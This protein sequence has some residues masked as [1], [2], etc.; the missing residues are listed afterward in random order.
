MELLISF[1]ASGELC[2]DLS[3]AHDLDSKARMSSNII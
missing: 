2:Q 3:D 1:A